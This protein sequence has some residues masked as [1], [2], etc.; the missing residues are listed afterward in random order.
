MKQVNGKMKNNKLKFLVT[1]GAG[2]I[3]SHIAETL[4]KDKHIVHIVDDLSGGYVE[5]IPHHSNCVFIEKSITDASAMD[6]LFNKHKYD[7]IIHL[8]CYAAEGLSHWIRH[9]NYTNNLIGSINLINCAI[10]YKIK[11]FIYTSSMSV[12]GSQTTPFDEFMP[13][14][15]EDPYAISK[16]AVEQDLKAANSLFGLPYIIFRPH[17]VYGS[18]QNLWDGNRNVIG[19]F[20]YQLL[21]GKAM[22]IFGN[23]DQT[24]AFSYISDVAPV[25]ANSWK[26]KNAYGRI[27]NIGGDVPITIN[28]LSE[29]VSKALDLPYN[30]VYLPTRYEVTHAYS[31]HAELEKYFGRRLLVT[32]EV[33]LSLMAEWAAKV[34]D[35]RGAKFFSD[36]ELHDK[37]PQKWIQK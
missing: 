32:P 24:R 3:G 17:N 2:F 15:P 27:F 8:A 25:I 19:I 14:K 36:I 1:G 30:A 11:G 10:K 5:N 16:V 23:G 6:E 37:I 26:N 22:T 20:M 34:Y 35:K 31:S 29:L 33:G 13:Y 21:T 7:Y 9:F 4:L 12:Y 28:K 18:M